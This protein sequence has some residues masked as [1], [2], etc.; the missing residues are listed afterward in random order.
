MCDQ[1]LTNKLYIQLNELTIAT[2]ICCDL[3]AP[4]MYVHLIEDIKRLKTN[5]GKG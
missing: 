2:H 3:G 4:E 5:Y 1:Y